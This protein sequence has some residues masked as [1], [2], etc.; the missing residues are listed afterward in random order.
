MIQTHAKRGLKSTVNC[1]Y[2]VD[3][4]KHI[5]LLIHA[6][7]YCCPELLITL[8]KVK[9]PRKLRIVKWRSTKNN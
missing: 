7:A 2:Y 1:T 3:G 5:E 9:N 8:T 6:K 4:K